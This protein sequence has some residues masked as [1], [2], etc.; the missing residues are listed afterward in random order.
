MA[1]WDEIVRELGQTKSQIDYIR[2]KYLK[3]L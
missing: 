2:A 3:E 1:G